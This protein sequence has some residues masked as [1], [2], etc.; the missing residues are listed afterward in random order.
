[1]RW[2]ILTD[3]H[4]PH[5][6]G[7]A[8]WTDA[9]ARGL[10]EA[11]HEVRLYDRRRVGGPSFARWGGWWLRLAARRDLAAADAVLATTWTVATGLVGVR[12]PIHIAFH[13]SDV[14]RPPVSGGFQRACRRATHRWAVSAWLQR[15]LAARGVAA[16]VLAAPVDPCPPRPPSTTP[17]VWGMVARAT[18]LKGGERFVR[19][20]AA[21]GT[22][23][24]VV[25]DGPELPRWRALARSLG[26]RVDFV[27]A[28]PR[29][30]VADWLRQM[31]LL[32]LLPRAHPDGTGGEGL[33]L[34]LIEAAA[35]GVPTV[36]CR[37]GGVPE[38]ASFLLENPDDPS[39]VDAI[40][41]W[42]TPARG[43]E[44]RAWLAQRH[45]VDK[46]VRTLV[47]E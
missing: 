40:R 36:G 16:R 20:V 11:G 29:A 39:S 23:G 1:M 4:V 31:D 6:G 32:L 30:A 41:R 10:A 17:Q 8:T 5:P 21:A 7:V 12:C 42:W 27:G 34:V 14:T 43:G 3:D 35:V 19:L 47:G 25:G 37:T 2:V 13:G 38:A 9:V 18:P 33:G 45:G 24:I 26:A 44:A 46:V 28:V 15:Q 22:R